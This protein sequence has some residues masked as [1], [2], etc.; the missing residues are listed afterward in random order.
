MRDI[1]LGLQIVA[2]NSKRACFAGPRDDAL[3]TK[4][5]LALGGRLPPS[6]REFV[7]K[8]GAGNFGAF[9]VYG[10][11]DGSFAGPVPD[12][13]WLTLDERAAGTIPGNLIIVGNNGEG[14]Y[15]CVQQDSESPVVLMWPGSGSLAQAVAPDFGAYFLAN[16]A[17]AATGPTHEW[18]SRPPNKRERLIAG[19]WLAANLFAWLS[20]FAEWN[21]FGGFDKQ[22]AI[23]T[24]VVG[25]ILVVFVFPSVRRL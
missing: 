24:T 17:S 4:A 16:V 11:V 19:I 8:L 23:A 12:A 7:S 9:E 25:F 5:E 3:I 14:G 6:Y 20:Y 18:D 15:L 21:L 2:E 22:V 10:V 13:V 1:D